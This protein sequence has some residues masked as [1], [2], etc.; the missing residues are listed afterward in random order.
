[1]QPDQPVSPPPQP[2][3]PTGTTSRQVSSEQAPEAGLL[4][5]LAA[6]TGVAS[7]RARLL[8]VALLPLRRLALGLGERDLARLGV[9]LR[10]RLSRLLSLSLS[11][12]LALSRDLHPGPVCGW[13]SEAG[14]QNTAT[15]LVV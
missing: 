10:L 3:A 5:G 12:P 15:L 13:R 7:L 14:L 8:L 6:L 9:L 2:Q 11:L 1:M 4:L